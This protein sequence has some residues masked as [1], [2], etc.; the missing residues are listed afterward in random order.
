MSGN[1]N[2][3]TVNGATLSTDRNGQT[4]KAY[5]FDGVDDFIDLNNPSILGTTNNFSIL[6]WVN[7]G[8][9]TIYGEFNAAAGNTRN[10]L[11]ISGNYLGLD[12][13][14]P[15]GGTVSSLEILELNQTNTWNQVG[16]VREGSNW[17]FFDHGEL[18]NSG[19]N[20]ENYSGSA[21]NL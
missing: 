16:Y 13:Y 19:S 8:T 10:Y 7:Y 14:F 3:G 18:L 6:A 4:N 20:A 21:P 11:K 2:H 9:G 15:A 5:Q 1:G 12:Q 17:S